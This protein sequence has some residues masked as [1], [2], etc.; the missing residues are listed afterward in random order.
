VVKGLYGVITGPR[1]F[2]VIESGGTGVGITEDTIF[3]A[4]IE[5]DAGVKSARGTA[6]PLGFR[7]LGSLE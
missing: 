2:G 6:G 4:G 3:C 5:T 7:D 1:F